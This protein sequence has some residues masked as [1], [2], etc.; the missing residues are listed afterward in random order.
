LRADLFPRPLNISPGPPVLG[1]WECSTG[2]FFHV[3]NLFLV[4]PLHLLTFCPSGDPRRDCALHLLRTLAVPPC[5]SSYLLNR[6]KLSL[7]CVDSDPQ[8]FSLHPRPLLSK[9]ILP[10]FFLHFSPNSRIPS[11]S[12]RALRFLSPTSPVT[13]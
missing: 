10:L 1:I 6:A 8:P 13:S 4:H 12:F 3:I 9:T 2:F 5:D 11:T 7:F